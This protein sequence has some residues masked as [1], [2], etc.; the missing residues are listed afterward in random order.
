[1]QRRV[2]AV[3]AA[4]GVGS[5]WGGGGAGFTQRAGMLRKPYIL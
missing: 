2:G 5:S 1:M 4:A 3:G